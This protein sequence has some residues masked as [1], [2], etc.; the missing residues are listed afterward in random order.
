MSE[1]HRGPPRSF[2]QPSSPPSPKRSTRSDSFGRASNGTASPVIDRFANVASRM[3][4]AYKRNQVESP[5]MQGMG[6]G[7]CNTMKLEHK[8]RRLLSGQR[9]AEEEGREMVKKDAGGRR[10]EEENYL[11]GLKENNGMEST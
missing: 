6:S 7:G 2:K 8:T 11:T 5:R 3:F 10:E 1:E 9:G 4:L